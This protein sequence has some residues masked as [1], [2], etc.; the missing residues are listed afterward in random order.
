[1]KTKKY[2]FYIV[3]IA[4]I[5]FIIGC[6][7]TSYQPRGRTGGYSDTQLNK[8]VFRVSFAGNGFTSRDRVTDFLLLRSSELTLQHGFKYF[9]ITNSKEYSYYSITPKST[10]SHIITKPV[11]NCT[12]IC[13]YKK[14]HVNNNI[15]VYNAKFIVK[16][17]KT[18]YGIK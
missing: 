5:F 3:I 10:G 2:L 15:I 16:S 12:I 18:K 14:P 1:M 6:A 13:F 11:E 4:N 9:I 8:N 17:L 7:A